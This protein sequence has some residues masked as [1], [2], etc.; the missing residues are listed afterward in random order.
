MSRRLGIIGAGGHGKV[1][2]DTALRCGWE[3]VVFFDGLASKGGYSIGRWDVV[4]VPEN[5]ASHGCDAFFVAIGNAQHR[6]TWCEWVL[7]KSLPLISL[8]DPS[9][10]ISSFAEIGE[11]SLVVAGSVINVDARV[12]R[13]AIIN[14]RASLDHD[15]VIGDYSHVCPAVALGGE[16]TVGEG[17]WLGIGCQVKQC[18]A[19]GNAVTVGAGAT[20][21]SDIQDGLT[22]VGTPARSV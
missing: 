3:E 18:I 20:V 12:G 8:V 15:C 10:V 6:R 17:S 22:V 13:G 1:A 14:T 19:I 4:D 21:V 9:A 2:A 5:A 7:S 11:G 16:V